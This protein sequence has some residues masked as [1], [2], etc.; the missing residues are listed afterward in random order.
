VFTA[1][2][3][4]WAALRLSVVGLAVWTTAVWIVRSL[5]ILAGDRAT[6]FKVVHGALAVVSIALAVWAVRTV[7]RAD[8]IDPDAVAAVPAGT[9]L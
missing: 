6:G 8:A 5:T 4:A 1:W 3:R 2:R 9:A 7:R